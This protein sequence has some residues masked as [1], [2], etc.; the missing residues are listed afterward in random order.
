M[1]EETPIQSTPCGKEWR[2]VKPG[3]VVRTPKGL[4]RVVAIVCRLDR[5]GNRLFGGDTRV[6]VALTDVLELSPLDVE[7]LERSTT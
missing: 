6:H 5:E 3:D 1:I 7:P 4:G 2:D